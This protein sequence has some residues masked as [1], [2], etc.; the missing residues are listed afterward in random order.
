MRRRH[1]DAY[2]D[3]DVVADGGSVRVPLVIMDGTRVVQHF[4]IHPGFTPVA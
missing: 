2:L 3:D 4:H 1:H